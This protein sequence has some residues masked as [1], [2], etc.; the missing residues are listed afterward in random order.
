V[1]WDQFEEM[2]F[3]FD[4]AKPLTLAAY[5]ASLPKT[6]LVE[7]VAVGDAMPPMPSY[8]DDN[9]YVPTPLEETYMAAWAS[10]PEDMRVAVEAA[11][12]QIPATVEHRLGTDDS[13]Y[14]HL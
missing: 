3:E 10:C 6:A 13:S 1:I 9:H 4:P 2:P 14:A 12:S 5:V 11:K 7:P 8:L